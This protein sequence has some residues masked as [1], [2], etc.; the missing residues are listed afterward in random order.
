MKPSVALPPTIVLCTAC[1]E[2]YALGG[3]VALT[4]ALRHL[5]AGGAPV[6]VYVLDG[7]MRPRTWARLAR[8][9]VTTGRKHDLVRLK[10]EMG[11]FAG[12][13]QD[14]GSS[15]M[16]Y[17]RLALPELVDEQ[18]LIYLDADMVVQADLT[19]LAHLHLGDAM[20]AA[21]P[22]VV[23]R[24][25]GNEGLPVRELGLPPDDPYLQAGFLIIDLPRWRQEKVSERV[26]AYL[27]A[28]P[29]HARYWDQSALNVVL[30]RRW[31]ALPANWNMPAWWADEGRGGC[32]LDG[33]LL[34]FVGPH[35]PWLLG[36]DQ[37]GS[38]GRFFAEVRRT[39][40]GNWRPNR[41][42]QALKYAKYRLSQLF[43]R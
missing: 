30:H 41:L 29:K 23:T 32:H 33:E 11:R 2:T 43:R 31:L 21:A 20:V 6:R 34:H 12:L 40:W 36:H 24:T 9:L 27:H 18:R 42:R 26:L 22:D 13:P 28:W 15:V 3:T 8:S 39:A 38:A 37:G 16:T 4:S 5:P 17:A 25:L 19:P 10:P 1:N 7:G 35:K 14:W